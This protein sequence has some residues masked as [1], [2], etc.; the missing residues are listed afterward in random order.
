LN[1]RFLSILIKFRLR[2]IWVS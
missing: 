1:L 2:K